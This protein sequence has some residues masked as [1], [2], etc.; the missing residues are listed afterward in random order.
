MP[1]EFQ[2]SAKSIPFNPLRVPDQTQALQ[3]QLNQRIQWMREDNQSM[4]ESRRNVAAGMAEHNRLQA[5]IQDQDLKTL[6]GMSKTLTDTLLEVHKDYR[7]HQFEL[8]FNQYWMGEGDSAEIKKYDENKAKLAAVG[9]ATANAATALATDGVEPFTVYRLR[10]LSGDQKA[11]FLMAMVSDKGMAYGPWLDNLI[12]TDDQTKIDLGGGRFITPADARAGGPNAAA[13]ATWARGQ[14]VRLNGLDG[15][16]LAMLN[17]KLI[18]YMKQG[19]EKVIAAVNDQANRDRGDQETQELLGIY[20]NGLRTNPGEAFNALNRNLASVINPETGKIY[21]Q[22]GARDLAIKVLKQLIQD[23]RE[24]GITVNTLNA[25]RDSPDLDGKS[26]WG[27]RFP[28]LF[29]GLGSEI[30]AAQQRDLQR[31]VQEEQQ[32]AKAL[33]EELISLAQK[34][35]G[36]TDAQKQE[37]K[38][39]WR[40][41][42]PTIPLPSSLDQYMTKEQVA[43]E[44]AEKILDRQLAN[45]V[46]IFQEDLRGYSDKIKIKY[47]PIVEKYNADIGKN[48][49]VQSMFARLDK[50]L[51]LNL[52]VTSTSSIPHPTFETAKFRARQRFMEKYKVYLEG[53]R[54][55]D[56]GQARQAAFNDLLTLIQ[57]GRDPKDPAG[58]FR[59]DSQHVGWGFPEFYPT[60]GSAQAY[61]KAKGVRRDLAQRIAKYGTHIGAFLQ[62]ERVIPEKDAQVL[63]QISKDPTINPPASVQVLTQILHQRGFKG[64]IWDVMD[65]QLNAFQPGATVRRPESVQLIDSTAPNIKQLFTTFA[66]PRRTDRGFATMPWSKDKIPNGWGILIEKAAQKYGLDPALLAGMLKHESGGWKV[67]ARSNRDKPASQQ[68]KGLAQLMDGTARELGV[69]NPDD[70]AQAIDAGARYLAQLLKK[71]GDIR[72]ALRAYNYGP[73]NTDRD[74]EGKYDKQARDYPDLVLREAAIYGYGNQGL[75]SPYMVHP[76]LKPF[77][78]SDIT[79]PI[80]PARVNPITGKVRPHNGDDLYAKRGSQLAFS[81][82]VK[83]ITSGNDPDGYGLWMEFELPNGHRV[84]KGHLSQIPKDF[85]RGMTIPPGKGVALSGSTGGSTG[86]HVHLEERDRSGRLLKP[87]REGGAMQYLLHS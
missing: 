10:Q 31:D 71:Y 7:K 65:L 21:R 85:T 34:Q 33:T 63:V 23:G 24:V 55:G 79:S 45:G 37:I 43:D 9:A 3:E 18:P 77:V 5:S 17:D 50:E 67:N 83:F 28:Q 36:L 26:T 42:F 16:N 72:I 32:N 56:T 51:S 12:A 70:P 52:R 40:N 80:D 74:L 60:G 58:E 44:V 57:K 25:I 73:G 86:P 13:V 11:G 38:D 4:I 8:G 75:R 61:E 54:T 48:P 29:S 62:N 35:G 82:P 69:T 87:S 78:A 14:Y 66:S 47:R 64:S 2:G 19:E 76:S 49:E 1:V 15:A 27:R 46:P 41:T 39:N 30:Y 53:S 84:L 68:A 22:G 81:V 59:V 6:A 20:T